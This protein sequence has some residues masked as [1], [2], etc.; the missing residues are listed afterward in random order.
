[1]TDADGVRAIRR[2]LAPRASHGVVQ[3]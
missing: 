1:V 3:T 2:Q